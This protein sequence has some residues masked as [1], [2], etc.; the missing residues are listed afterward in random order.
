MSSPHSSSHNME[1]ASD[2]ADF[3][4]ILCPTQSSRAESTSSNASS[5]SKVSVRGLINYLFVNWLK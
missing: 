2:G 4:D 5:D 1:I 3:D